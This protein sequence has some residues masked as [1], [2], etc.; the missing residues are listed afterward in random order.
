MTR[1]LPRPAAIHHDRIV[2]PMLPNFLRTEGGASL[3]VSA[4]PDSGLRELGRLWTQALLLH[5]QKKR[6]EVQS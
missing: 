2:L 5:A 3:P 1:R 6:K 4:V